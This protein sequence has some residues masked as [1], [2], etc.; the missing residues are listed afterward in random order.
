MTEKEATGSKFEDIRIVDLD[1]ELSSRL[2]Q[3]RVPMDTKPSHKE[4]DVYRVF[5]VLSAP[6]PREWQRLFEER[7]RYSRL[8]LSGASIQNR[9]IVIDAS[10][11]QVE[12]VLPDLQKEVRSVN[13]VYRQHLTDQAEER[14]RAREQLTALKQRLKFD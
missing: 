6:P 8:P 9:H 10:L 7:R 4:D 12:A 11:K 13:T 5:F 3:I 14:S 2:D 1:E